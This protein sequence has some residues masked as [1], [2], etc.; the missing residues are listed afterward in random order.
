MQPGKQFMSSISLNQCMHY[1]I[2]HLNI[3]R[4]CHCYD[5]AWSYFY[6]IQAFIQAY[7]YIF[8]LSIMFII[9]SRPSA[10]A[11]APAARWSS[12]HL[13][14]SNRY[15]NNMVM[16]NILYRASWWFWKC[17]WQHLSIRIR[18]FMHYNIV[19]LL[20]HAHAY[21]ALQNE[22]FTCDTC[23]STQ[24]CVIKST[25]I[26]SLLIIYKLLVPAEDD[27]FSAQ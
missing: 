4:A 27:E 9:A 3:M 16:Q 6:W 12:K 21:M 11:R 20:F 23:A 2:T 5:C 17:Q 18:Q 8:P 25:S 14:I 1:G 15:I 19:F 7:R 10:N 13:S 22:F 26:H 24:I